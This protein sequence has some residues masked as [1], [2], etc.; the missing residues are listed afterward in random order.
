MKIRPL[1]TDE[2]NT[3]TSKVRRSRDRPEVSVI[4]VAISA[5]AAKSSFPLGL[6]TGGI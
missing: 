6:I 3:L 4:C 2:Q 5:Q 1:H